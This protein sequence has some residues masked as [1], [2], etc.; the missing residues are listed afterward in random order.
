[1]WRISVTLGSVKAGYS[2]HNDR[3]PSLSPT[4]VGGESKNHLSFIFLSSFLLF[5]SH[6]LMV[7]VARASNAKEMGDSGLFQP[8]THFSSLLRRFTPPQLVDSS[9]DLV[10]EP[11]KILSRYVGF[12]FLI[13]RIAYFYPSFCGLC[14]LNPVCLWSE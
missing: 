10:Y 11:Q 1:M 4:R 14:D 9:C 13:F 5:S 2:C 3:R 12:N 8:N 7:T 6:K